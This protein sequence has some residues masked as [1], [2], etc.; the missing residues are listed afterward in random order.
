MDELTE[1]DWLQIEQTANGCIGGT[2]DEW[3]DLRQAI[4]K[5]RGKPLTHQRSSM[6]MIGFCE[7][8]MCVRPPSPV[9]YCFFCCKP[10]CN[11]ECLDSK[12]EP[13]NGS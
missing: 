4:E 10:D 6:W 3:P 1:H 11:N 2:S 7:A 9:N 12:N 8:L 13:S 5:V